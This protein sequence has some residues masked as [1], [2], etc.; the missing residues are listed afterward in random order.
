MINVTVICEAKLKEKYLREACDEYIKRLGAFCKFNIIE[1]S[2]KKLPDNPSDNEIKTALETEG[3]EI[4]SKIPKGSRVYAMCIEGKQMSSE[5][6]AKQFSE[7]AIGGYSSIVFVIGSSFGL[8]DEVKRMAD[9]KLSM[10][11]MTFPHQLAR[12]MLLEQIYR[13]FTINAGTKYHK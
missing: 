2:P 7:C 10:S 8:S 4:I 5:N 11:Q 6:L 3:R 1:L 12:V 9:F 13:A